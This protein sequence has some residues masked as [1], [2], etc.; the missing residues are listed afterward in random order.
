MTAREI[1]PI[2]LFQVPTVST[3]VLCSVAQLSA[4]LTWW[5]PVDPRK[6]ETSQL[7]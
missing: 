1:I 4:V 3:L 6:T 5:T 2:G 7:T